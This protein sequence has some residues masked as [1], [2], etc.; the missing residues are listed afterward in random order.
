MGA[1]TLDCGHDRR[2][3]TCRDH[4][5]AGRT[6]AINN[7]KSAGNRAVRSGALKW[8]ITYSLSKLRCS[9]S[10]ATMSYWHFQYVLVTILTA[11][12][13]TPVYNG[14]LMWKPWVSEIFW[15]FS[16]RHKMRDQH[17]INLGKILIY[18]SKARWCYYVSL[19]ATWQEHFQVKKNQKRREG[20]LCL[21]KSIS[22]V[23][24]GSHI[25]RRRQPALK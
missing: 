23:F 4:L 6:R 3:S 12:C 10:A 16:I 14:I 21:M 8:H 24:G 25:I 18:L 11:A 22:F 2:S 13:F 5:N 17:A 7:I 19:P 15:L 20:L 1:R 9:W